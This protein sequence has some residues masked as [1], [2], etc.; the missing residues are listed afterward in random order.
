MKRFTGRILAAIGF[1]MVA[2]VVVF[3]Q[4]PLVGTVEQSVFYAGMLLIAV[5]GTIGTNKIWP[6]DS[7]FRIPK[8]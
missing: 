1:I 8:P 7:G 6:N 3:Q 5:G 2:V 4:F